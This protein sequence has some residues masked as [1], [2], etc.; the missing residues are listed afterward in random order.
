MIHVG[1]KHIVH[2]DLAARNVLI[3]GDHIVK[4]CDFGIARLG[5]YKKTSTELRY[6]PYL[7]MAIESL[8]QP[9]DPV[10]T[11]ETDVWSFGILLWEIF[12]HRQEPYSDFPQRVIV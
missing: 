7:W 8:E 1:K 11:T 4:I 9:L 3:T 12:S 10:F 6:F 2:C 5:P